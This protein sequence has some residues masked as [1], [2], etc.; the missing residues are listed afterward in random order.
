MR[1]AERETEHVRSKFS[2]GSLIAQRDQAI[3]DRD[4][5][6]K[7]LEEAGR[8]FR[9]AD[10]QAAAVQFLTLSRM[11]AVADRRIGR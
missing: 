9:G 1:R 6:L 5:A 2:A 4:F 11:V 10:A 3:A 7:F 8:A